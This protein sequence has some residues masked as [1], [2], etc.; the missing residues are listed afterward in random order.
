MSL[1]VYHIFSAEFIPWK[2]NKTTS[3]S[4]R[5]YYQLEWISP[6]FAP[7]SEPTSY[8]ALKLIISGFQC[9]EEVVENFILLLQITFLLFVAHFIIIC[10]F[11]FSSVLCDKH[12]CCY[13]P[14]RTNSNRRKSYSNWWQSN[15]YRKFLLFS[16]SENHLKNI[17]TKWMKRVFSITLIVAKICAYALVMFNGQMNEF[18]WIILNLEFIPNTVNYIM[19]NRIHTVNHHS[20]SWSII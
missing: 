8:V 5:P 6:F 3:L 15:A 17:E 19:F 2:S 4:N 10:I 11:Y 13:F 9:L 16:S 12:C 7:H 20:Q 1:Q 18:A 14:H